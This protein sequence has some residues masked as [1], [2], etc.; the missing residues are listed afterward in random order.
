MKKNKKYSGKYYVVD[1]DKF[2]DI[3]FE[4]KILT[5]PDIFTMR[6]KEK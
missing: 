4:N 5:K 3:E 2:N 6:R 1:F